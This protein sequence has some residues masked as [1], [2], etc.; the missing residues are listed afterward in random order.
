MSQHQQN[1]LPSIVFK[2]GHFEVL[3]EGMVDR[4]RR[5]MTTINLMMSTKKISGQSYK[6][7]EA[8]NQW[9]VS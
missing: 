2:K 4:F 9:P 1:D 7:F 3:K 5:K 6:H 8:R